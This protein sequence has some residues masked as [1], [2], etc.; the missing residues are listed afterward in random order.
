MYSSTRCI[1]AP[2]AEVEPS[3][4]EGC[5]EVIMIVTEFWSVCRVFAVSPLHIHG[6]VDTASN[7]FCSSTNR[8]VECMFHASSII[9]CTLHIAY[10]TLHIAD[11]RELNIA[12][13]EEVLWP[14][15]KEEFM[16]ACIHHIHHS[17]EVALQTQNLNQDQ[18]PVPP[19]RG[20]EVETGKVVEG[21]ADGDGNGEAGD[22]QKEGE[23]GV[24][25]V[26]VAE[27]LQLMTEK[28]LVL[29]TVC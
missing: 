4:V 8:T 17:H 28:N 2:H 9:H 26:Y 16:M 20:E 25:G 18:T 22:G 7:T 14:L 13:F 21:T 10:Y 15:I 1:S 23:V 11:E 12:D 5:T 3:G 6:L 27:T 19:P 29:C 24:T